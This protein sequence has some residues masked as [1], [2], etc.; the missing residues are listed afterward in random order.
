MHFAL[1]LLLLLLFHLTN[2]RIAFRLALSH[3]FSIY[4]NACVHASTT[5]QPFAGPSPI[6][7][8][9]FWG[10]F[11]FLSPVHVLVSYLWWSPTLRQTQLKAIFHCHEEVLESNS[12]PVQETFQEMLLK[13]LAKKTTKRKDTNT[14]LQQGV[15]KAT[16]TYTA[17]ISLEQ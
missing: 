14:I 8:G 16:L 5:D 3:S 9:H 11:P 13:W 12:R 6:S 2:Q 7:Q 17:Q 10:I 1:H 4:E 15:I